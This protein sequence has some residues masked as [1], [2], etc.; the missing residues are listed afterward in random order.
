MPQNPDGVPKDKPTD[1]WVNNIGNLL[2]LY[3]KTNGKLQTNLQTR[4]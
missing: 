2:P 1:E 3:F 4:K